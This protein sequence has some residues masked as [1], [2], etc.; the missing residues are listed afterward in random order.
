MGDQ[1]APSTRYI[2]GI[3]VEFI[4]LLSLVCTSYAWTAKESSS[5]QGGNSDIA[6]IQVSRVPFPYVPE[7]SWGG[8]GGGDNWAW[9]QATLPDCLLG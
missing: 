8:G 5:R 3:A 9:W 1:L 7:A 4:L 6:S 2:P